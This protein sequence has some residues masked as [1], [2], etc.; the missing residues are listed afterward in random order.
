[1]FGIYLRASLST[2]TAAAAAAAAR[3]ISCCCCC[4]PD[5]IRS[6]SRWSWS[7]CLAWSLGLAGY[8]LATHWHIEHSENVVEVCTH[9]GV[10]AIGGGALF[11]FNCIRFW[12]WFV[13]FVL[14][15]IAI[16]SLWSARSLGWLRRRWRR[17][18]FVRLLF[19]NLGVILR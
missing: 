17:F 7:W 5:C 16:R 8:L 12:L 15:L 9:A 3:S 6:R 18:V 10:K 13:F 19:G 14:R 1:M 2:C 11:L 4:S